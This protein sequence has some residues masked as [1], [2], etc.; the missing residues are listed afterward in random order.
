[1][2]WVSR[3]LTKQEVIGESIPISL[4]S[5]PAHNVLATSNCNYWTI[6]TMMS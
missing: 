6:P 1:M 2:H 4:L 3:L 5:V